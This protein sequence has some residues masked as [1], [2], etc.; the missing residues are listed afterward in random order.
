MTDM[1]AVRPQAS[2]YVVGVHLR[3]KAKPSRTGVG[4]KRN[5]T[6]SP[7]ESGLVA[8]SCARSPP[9][10]TPKALPA[11]RRLLVSES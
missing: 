8:L 5:A 11:S 4:R 3:S 10:P 7:P 1:P 6:R 9:L 2:E